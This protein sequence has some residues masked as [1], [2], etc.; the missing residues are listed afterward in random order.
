MPAAAWIGDR[1]VPQEDEPGRADV[2]EE[3]RLA[4][5]GLFV[6]QRRLRGRDA[7]IV[8][9]VSFAHY[10]LLK[11]LQ[12]AGEMSAG[13]LASE[14][15]LTPATVTQMLEALASAG[16]VERQ[17]SERDRRVVTSR[18]TEEGRRRLERKDAELVEKWRDTLADLDDADLEQATRVVARIAA[19][20]D[21]L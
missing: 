8:G 18:M 6:S 19:Y 5:A 16:I 4:T 11:A 12:R 9:G 3:L 20:L 17:R 21:A 1:P 2:L 7:R 10:P 15:A 14:V 13:Q